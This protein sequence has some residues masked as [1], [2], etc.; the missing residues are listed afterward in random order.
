[1]TKSM[2]LTFPIE[3]GFGA[4]KISAHFLFESLAFI[5]GYQYYQKLRRHSQDVISDGN[6]IWIL[7]GAAMGALLFSRLVAALEDPLAWANSN[8]P[9]LYLYQ[10]KTIVGGLAGGLLGVELTKYWIQEK[11]SSGD[12]FTFPI[13]L[14]MIIGRIGCFS[15]GVY[16]PTF[17]I[18]TT[19]PWGMNLGDGLKRH[20]VTLYEITYL[21]LVWLGIKYLNRQYHLKDGSLFILFMITYYIFR[22][23]LEYIKPTFGYFLGFTSIQVT[24]I[25]ILLYYLNY[26]IN[27]K[28]FLANEK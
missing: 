19:L 6:R 20:P 1:M 14:A 11:H 7:I 9:I 25:I 21:V 17:G 2:E 13:I 24:C 4:F 12:L 27:P 16:E 3:V 26:I 5:L 18:E 8:Y 23:F 28:K 10:S 15:N 22:F